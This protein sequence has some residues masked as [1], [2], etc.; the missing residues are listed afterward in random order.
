M[1]ADIDVIVYKAILTSFSLLFIFSF[2]VLSG[3][4]LFRQKLA[5]INRDLEK[6]AKDLEEKKLDLEEFAKIVS[7]DLKTPLRNI[8]ALSNWVQQD[9][10]DNNTA[11]VKDNL[12]LIEKEIIQMDLILEGVLNYSLQND[13]SS[14]HA[15][16]NLDLLV[17]DLKV[18]YENKNCVMRIKNELPTLD[19]NKSQILLVFQNIVQNAI[20]FNDKEICEIEIDYTLENNFHSFSVSDNGIGIE[21]RFYD[22]IF[23][24]FQKLEVDKNIGSMGIGLATVKKVIKMNKGEIYLKSKV[25]IGTTFYFTLPV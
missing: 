1:I 14:N 5:S 8:L 23:E 21:E 17:Q 22:K 10:K 15:K 20:K 4:T 25:N 6:R 24:L 7:H 12:A 16:V 18:F 9:L 2:I 11:A 19:I 3:A 13:V